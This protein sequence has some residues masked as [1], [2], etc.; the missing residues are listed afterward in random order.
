MGRP[1]TRK[2]HMKVDSEK[3]FGFFALGFD[4]AKVMKQASISQRSYYYAKGE[5]DALPQTRKDEILAEARKSYDERMFDREYW[6]K[7]DYLHKQGESQIPIIQKWYDVMVMRKV[8]PASIINRMRTFHDICLGL[9]GRGKNKVRI[10][11]NK[12]APHL[13]EE[14]D[15]VEWI[16]TLTKKKLENVGNARLVIRNFLKFGK[17]IEPTQISGEKVGYGEMVTEYFRDEELDSIYYVLDNAVSSLGTE[18][19]FYAQKYGINADELQ[20]CVKTLVMFLHHSATRIRA[21]LRIKAENFET[22][23]F[24]DA[25]A[26][27]VTVFDKGKEGKEKRVKPILAVLQRQLE[28]YG[29]RNRK[30]ANLPYE[31]MFPFKYKDIREIMKL[32]Y[33][34]AGIKREIRQ[35]LHIWRHTFAMHYHRRTNYNTAFCCM[36]GGWDDE[37]TFKDCYGA[38]ELKDFIPLALSIT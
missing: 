22:F 10:R 1:R 34:K 12:I 5:F 9:A 27:K 4:K 23:Q 25:K 19:M 29:I 37:K 18:L 2:R 7:W 16:L 28:S 33:E 26:M 8:K 17:G 21:S 35:P 30:Y 13:F 20:K 32:V 24:Q 11:E 6:F 15:G 38:P 3:I 14:K 36:V 31:R